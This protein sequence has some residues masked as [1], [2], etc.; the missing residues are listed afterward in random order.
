MESLKL[1]KIGI[2]FENI[3]KGKVEDTNS[4]TFMKNA[5]GDA[6]FELTQLEND[7]IDLAKGALLIAKDAY[8]DLD[9]E[10]YI[11]RLNQMAEELQ[12]QIGE[13]RG[14]E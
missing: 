4:T 13:G 1:I 3:K 5:A 8:A 10:V 9:I 14:Y 2:S 7:Q 11:Q 12:S 6:L